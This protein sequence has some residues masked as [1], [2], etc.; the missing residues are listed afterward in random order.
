MWRQTKKTK[1]D[2]QKLDETRRHENTTQNHGQ[3]ESVG[4]T[5]VASF[6]SACNNGGMINDGKLSFVLNWEI[7]SSCI[8][9]AAM[10]YL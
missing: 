6:L 10:Y 2:T 4:S 5:F 9:T 8:R 7:N 1:T 3:V